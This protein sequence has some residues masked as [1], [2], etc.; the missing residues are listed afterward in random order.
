M[1]GMSGMSQ[2]AKSPA[3]EAMMAGMSQMNH[4]M[5]AAPMTGNPDQDFVAMMIPH[6]QGAVE[7]S[8]VELQ[9]GKDPRLRRLAQEMII[10][11]QSEIDVMK[12]AIGSFSLSSPSQNRKNWCTP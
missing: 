8:K 3:D 1:A 4:D 5:A 12:R 10:T 6:H 9:F 7:M 2:A 11:Q